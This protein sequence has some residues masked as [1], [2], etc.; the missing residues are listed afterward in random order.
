MFN[1]ALNQLLGQHLWELVFGKFNSFFHKFIHQFIRGE[2]LLLNIIFLLITELQS[3]FKKKSLY[4]LYTA[5]IKFDCSPY[6]NCILYFLI[7]H[8]SEL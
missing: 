2:C 5:T 8:K 4:I 1:R 7:I 6:F 3:F